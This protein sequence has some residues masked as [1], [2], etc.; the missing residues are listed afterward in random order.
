MPRTKADS[1]AQFEHVVRALIRA[2]VAATFTH[3]PGETA[4]LLHDNA[5]G[6]EATAIIARE[7]IDLIDPELASMIGHALPA[8]FKA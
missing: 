2:D 6:A 5:G 8:P 7:S 3:S 4:V 1:D